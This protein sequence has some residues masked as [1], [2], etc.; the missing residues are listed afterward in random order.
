[1]LETF[2]RFEN[3]ALG[4][5]TGVNAYYGID[6]TEFRIESNYGPSDLRGSLK[7]RMVVGALFI[8]LGQD[9]IDSILKINDRCHATSMNLL[10][11]ILKRLTE[12]DLH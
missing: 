1:M 12:C 8:S 11:V 5:F 10:L 9:V 4:Y 3:L 6:F 7:G 2:V